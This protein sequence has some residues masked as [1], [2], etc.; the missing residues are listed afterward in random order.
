MTYIFS[1]YFGYSI[2]RYFVIAVCE[3]HE[4]LGSRSI[5]SVVGIG[6]AVLSHVRG[7]V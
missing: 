7:Q 5:M 6:M 4:L 3:F 2:I 1:C